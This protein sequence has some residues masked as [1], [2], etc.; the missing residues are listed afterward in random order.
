MNIPYGGCIEL[1]QLGVS[2]ETELSRGLFR[3]ST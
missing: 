1:M 3:D 2:R